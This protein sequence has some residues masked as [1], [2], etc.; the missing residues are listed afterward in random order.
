MR[1]IQ[2][3]RNCRRIGAQD[4]ELT[5]VGRPSSSAGT[6]APGVFLAKSGRIYEPRFYQIRWGLPHLASD[7]LLMSGEHEVSGLAAFGFGLAGL[8]LS[9][10]GRRPG[11]SDI[12]VHRPTSC[13]SSAPSLN[14]GRYLVLA[15][16]AASKLLKSSPPPRESCIAAAGLRVS[17]TEQNAPPTSPRDLRLGSPI[18]LTRA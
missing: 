3:L 13:G 12:G 6:L 15:H 8:A 18:N 10:T 1:S 4:A 7:P 14:V 9:D 2:E 5:C 16:L 17:D 11:V